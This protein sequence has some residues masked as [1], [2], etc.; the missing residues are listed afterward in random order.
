MAHSSSVRQK[1]LNRPALLKAV[2]SLMFFLLNVNALFIYIAFGSFIL[3]L[4]IYSAIFIGSFKPIYEHTGKNTLKV[5][6][7][8]F[9]G[10]FTVIYALFSAVLLPIAYNVYQSVKE[11]FVIPNFSVEQ[12]R[13]ARNLYNNFKEFTNINVITFMFIGGLL[14]VSFAVSSTR[15]LNCEKK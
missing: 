9:G 6:Y 15:I 7:F 8:Q 11:S 5:L 1:I 12:I 10:I 13:S 4:F 2:I 14:L 3:T